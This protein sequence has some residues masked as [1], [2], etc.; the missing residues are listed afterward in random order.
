MAETH[1][2]TAEFCIFLLNNSF[3]LECLNVLRE[4]PNWYVFSLNYSWCFGEGK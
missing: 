4:T 2:I 3:H 1:Q